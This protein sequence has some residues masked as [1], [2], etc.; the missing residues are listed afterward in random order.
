MSIAN[1]SDRFSRESHR[2]IE[3]VNAE[4]LY[5]GVSIANPSELSPKAV[6]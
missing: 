1:P 4:N 2:S 5:P 6:R 3:Y